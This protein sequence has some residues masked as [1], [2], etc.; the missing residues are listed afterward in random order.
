MGTVSVSVYFILVGLT[1][2]AGPPSMTFPTHS[3][4]PFQRGGFRD[5][6]V[7]QTLL[8]RVEPIGTL[9]IQGK[10]KQSMLGPH[11]D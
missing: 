2:S 5:V 6:G 3:G 8:E 1:E 7:S 4:F 9:W 11:G 10:F